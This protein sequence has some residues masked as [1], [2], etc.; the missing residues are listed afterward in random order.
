MDQQK[1]YLIPNLKAKERGSKIRLYDRVDD[2]VELLAGMK[3]EKPS[4][5]ITKGHFTNDDDKEE[6]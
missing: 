6:L 5:W 2:D 1:E 3:V 4:M